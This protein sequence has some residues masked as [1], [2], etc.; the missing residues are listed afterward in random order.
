MTEGLCWL[1]ATH[2][3]AAHAVLDLVLRSPDRGKAWF[4]R[5]QMNLGGLGRR[6]RP[7][8]IG[9]GR[10]H[11]ILFENKIDAPVDPQQLL[12]HRHGAQDVARGRAIVV[13]LVARDDAVGTDFADVSIRWRDMQAALRR[14]AGVDQESPMFMQFVEFLGMEGLG[15][16]PGPCPTFWKA[17]IL[18]ARRRDVSQGLSRGYFD[19]GRKFASSILP[20]A[21]EDLADD[22]EGADAGLRDAFDEA[23]ESDDPERGIWRLCRTFF[24]SY[25][26]STDERF[27]GSLRLTERQGRPFARG[28]IEYI[29]EDGLP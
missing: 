22:D 26:F 24:P 28:M 18:E 5:T 23:L 29:Q 1:V 27:G 11:V 9:E 19:L 4:W 16:V 8:M 6:T 20:Q 14:A 25:L 7:D 3:S 10:N 13:V 21:L 12:E 17:N 15:R 2:E